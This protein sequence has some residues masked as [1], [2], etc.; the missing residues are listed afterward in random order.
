M[1]IRVTEEGEGP[2][3]EPIPRPGGY[4][5]N[6]VPIPEE[7]SERIAAILEA[8]SRWLE[9]IDYW[10]KANEESTAKRL[11]NAEFFYEESQK[12][13]VRYFE[14]FYTTWP[15]KQLAFNIV[16]EAPTAE[17]LRKVVTL[18]FDAKD[19]LTALW[20][21]VRRRREAITF[22]ELQGPDWG[23]FTPATKELFVVARIIRDPVFL[24]SLEN[25]TN[26][27]E[28]LDYFALILATVFIP[29]ARAEMNRLRRNFNAAIEDY[30][31]L[32]TPYRKP[33]SGSPL[34]WLTCDFIERP[35]ILLALGETRFEKAE[36]QF[37]AASQGKADEARATYQSIPELFKDHGAYATRVTSAQTML[38][39][40]ANH[41]I[42]T[43]SNQ[44][45]MT[46]Q[47]LGNDITVPGIIS[48]T[49]ELPGLSQTKAPGESWLLL[50]DTVNG[51]VIAET[52]P[53]IYALLLNAQARL[54]QI[55]NGFNYIGYKNDYIPPW[56]F[57]FLLERARYFSEH[58][59]NAQRDYLNFLSNAEREE[60]QEQS[61]AQ[62]V[63]MEKANVRI[64][65]ARVEQV[66][67]EVTA[68]RESWK[69]AQAVASNAQRRFTNYSNL[70]THLR[71]LEGDSLRTSQRKSAFNYAV[72]A[73][74]GNWGLAISS[75]TEAFEIFGA[76][77][78]RVQNQ[79]ARAQRSYEKE[80]LNAA[81]FE[82]GRAAVIAEIKYKV[83]QAGFTVSCL[84]RQASLL[85]HEF[86]IQ[87]LQYLRSRTLNAEQWFR[88]ANAIR[89]VADTY[90]RYAVE[91][92]FQSEQAYEFEADKR[93]NVI[94]FDYDQSE[95][96]DYLAADFLL[97]DLDTI[98]Q[99]FIVNQR[100]RQQQ[101]RYVLSL[102]REFP[103]ALEELRKNG[104][105]DFLL[106]LEQI[107]KRFP[108][109]Y[110]ARVGMVDVLPVALM[111]S[112]RFSLDLTHTGSGQ[113]RIKGQ[114]DMR[115]GVQSES[116]FNVSDLPLADYDWT[117][118]PKELWPVKILV[119]EPETAVFSGL[120]RQDAASAF[121]VASSGQRNAFEGRGLAGGWQIDMSARENQVVPDSLADLLIT[122]TV[123]GYHDPGLRAAIDGAKLQTTALTSYLSARQIF[124]DAFYDFSCTGRMVWR[125]P[126]EMLA[127]NGDLGRLRNIG[128]SLRPGAPDAHFSRLMAQFQM[129]F[130]VNETGGVA[131]GV[132]LFTLI[133]ETTVTQTAPLTVAVRARSDA[134]TEL[135][136]DF[137]DGT[138]ILRTVRSGTTPIAPA[139]GAH[140]YAKPGR[141]VMKL[142]CV[143]N[144]SLSEFRIS[145]VVSRNQKL[146]DPL[147]IQP[148]IGFDTTAKTVTIITT[149]AVQQAG[150][151]LWRVGDLTAEGNSASFA[152]KP[153]NYILDFAAVRKLNFKAYG[154]QRYV[155]ESGSLP[156]QGFSAATN[157]TFNENGAETNGTG[158]PPLP[159]RNEL[160]KRLFDKGAISPEDDWTFE[161]IA[162]EILGL[163]AGTAVGAEE[164]ELSD[165]QDVVLSMEYDITP[166][167]S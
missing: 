2:T 157:R 91:L 66:A 16:P 167:S 42:E 117:K 13:V 112:T 96:G 1:A 78:V 116:I 9:A 4:P 148:R 136:W 139:E 142:R 26:R 62:A 153:G 135:A 47:A 127:L 165:I 30:E 114:P 113:M 24:A 122:F 25:S 17:K 87:N 147:I 74:T 39:A 28:S 55:E 48:N 159:V 37:K 63:E 69:L 137:G 61:A 108:G 166:G 115:V 90:L 57:Q 41:P 128:M 89:G 14:K 107:E 34:I 6:P 19:S 65:S 8:R 133:P 32:L 155:R 106:R 15:V 125:V 33:A 77:P 140:V 156:L 76:S 129:N 59:K 101:V 79:T 38:T 73:A 12:A 149:G 60:F 43:A 123:S 120:S 83:A 81:I 94:R 53:R 31:R 144:E 130:R 143:Q 124:P 44:Q 29:L 161:L 54:L 92:A 80:N 45:D 64:E 126:R 154:A 23:G 111:D 110:N 97:S 52:N 5:P 103:A 93:I 22:E 151:M 150:R 10:H 86:A 35:F 138:P 72:G 163:P 58:A 134:A 70:D 71:D 105:V 68:A 7:A 104:K 102:A 18:L 121:P 158:T 46:L 99:D 98:E 21:K 145:V 95:V 100:Q 118:T 152:L 36:V 20:A 27:Q 75:Y 56:R 132:S 109:L 162:Q 85:R 141:Y 131:S 51:E 146:G 88:L 119:N 40:Q 160:A 11:A 50:Q 82:T 49:R 84:Q 164:L 67:A 3:R